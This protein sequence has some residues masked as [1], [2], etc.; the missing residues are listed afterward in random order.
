M[1][2][3]ASSS[4]PD[5]EYTPPPAPR[6]RIN[7]AL[8]H[9]LIVALGFSALACLGLLLLFRGDFGTPLV[10]AAAVYA[11]LGVGLAVVEGQRFLAALSVV[12]LIP[13]ALVLAFL[14]HW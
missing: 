11:G 5:G 9:A 6:G 7:N 10:M 4:N 14:S 1:T 3:Q 13:V 12:A 8:R 2:S